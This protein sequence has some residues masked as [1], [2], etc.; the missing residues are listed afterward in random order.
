MTT[1]ALR[2]LLIETR[3]AGF[4]PRDKLKIEN[5][6]LAAP[7]LDYGVVTQRLISEQLGP[8]FG[9]ISVYTNKKDRALSVS[10]MIHSGIRFGKL[11]PGQSKPQEDAV[12]DNVKNV[13]FITVQGGK[14]GFFNHGYFTKDPA[15]LS[16]IITLIT[17][18][19]GPGTEAR[20]L[21]KLDGNFWEMDSDY[22]KTSELKTAETG[23]I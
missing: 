19:G 3:A 10:N 6:I 16:D 13:D 1:T 21:N 2:E 15:T 9:R 5:L 17:K 23:R 22:L 14:E 4:N 18:P 7:D 20:P 12:F 11:L 8:A